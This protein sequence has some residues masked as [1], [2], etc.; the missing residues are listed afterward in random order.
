LQEQKLDGNPKEKGNGRQRKPT[1]A[2][3]PF[4]TLPASRNK[5][6]QK[7]LKPTN[8]CMKSSASQTYLVR[9]HVARAP[10][11]LQATI[12]FL[13]PSLSFSHCVS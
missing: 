3:N 7:F 10:R 5:T 8:H 12:C 6:H 2:T 4:K 11:I 1:T 13:S 9:I